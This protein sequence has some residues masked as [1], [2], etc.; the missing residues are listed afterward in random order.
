MRL[1]I[2]RWAA[3]LAF[4]AECPRALKFFNDHRGAVLQQFVECRFCEHGNHF[5]FTPALHFKI[6]R[7]GFSALSALLPDRAGFWFAPHAVSS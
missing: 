5:Q 3:R 2:L 1:L 4:Q 7:D 6:D